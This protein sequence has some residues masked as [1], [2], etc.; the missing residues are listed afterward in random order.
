M[1]GPVL[2]KDLRRVFLYLGCL[3][4]HSIDHSDFPPPSRIQQQALLGRWYRLCSAPV[5]PHSVGIYFGD[6]LARTIMRL[7]VVCLAH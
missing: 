2:A 4:D 6:S 1:Y 5:S 7:L 3:I